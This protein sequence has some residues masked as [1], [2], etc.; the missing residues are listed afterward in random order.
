[1]SNITEIEIETA[2]DQL[3]NGK[4]PGMDFLPTEFYKDFKSILCPIL[5]EI[6]ID[7]L[8]KGELTQSMK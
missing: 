6:Y 8:K 1:M 2:I 3:R 4:S 5:N 7:V